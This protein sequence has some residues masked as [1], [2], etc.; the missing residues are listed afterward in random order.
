MA[1]HMAT[2]PPHRQPPTSLPKYMVHRTGEDLAHTNKTTGEVTIHP[3]QINTVIFPETG[4]SQEYIHLMKGPDK[5]KFTRAVANNI[6]RILQGIRC[7]KVT[8]TC[9]FIHRHKVTQYSKVTYSRIVCDIMPH[10]KETHILRV[11]VGCDKLTYNGP[12][13]TP[14]QI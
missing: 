4:K 8:Y 1:N 5:P 13:S 2:I 11:A 3:E 7:I 12:I 14:Q 6:G 10:N 9:Y